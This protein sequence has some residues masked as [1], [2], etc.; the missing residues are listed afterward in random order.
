MSTEEKFVCNGVIRC[1][2][3]VAIPD[4]NRSLDALV[5]FADNFYS[6]K[7]AKRHE[8]LSECSNRRE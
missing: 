3:N 5:A 2:W 7:I 6:V 4:E 8:N 1:C